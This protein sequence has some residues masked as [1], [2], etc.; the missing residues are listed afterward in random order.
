MTDASGVMNAAVPGALVRSMTGARRFVSYPFSDVCGPVADGPQ[1]S[2]AIA[3]ALSSGKGL[4]GKTWTRSELRIENGA[5]VERYSEYLGY[6]SHILRLA[7][8]IDDI[9][10]S[11]H[12]DCVQRRIKKAFRSGL[13]VFEGS[14][15]SD[16]KEFYRLHLMTRKKLGAP[17]QPFSF[18]RNMHKLLAPGGHL[19][20]L[21][22]KK[23]KK[24]VSGLVLLRYGKRASYKFA[25]SDESFLSLGGNQLA[26]WTAIRKASDDGLLEFD[27]GRSFA[28]NSGLNGFKARWGAEEVRLSYLYSP[29]KSVGIKDEGGSCAKVA[30]ALLR[31]LPP[32]SNRLIGRLFYKYLA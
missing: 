21:I 14:T 24:P 8:P 29:E 1:E 32:F 11:F 30:S 19:S 22:V 7:R 5:S 28:G 16:V 12:K 23:G 20:V 18:F 4:Q 3:A 17:V 2:G 25:A 6:S 13:E 15:I 10:A 26:I 9:Y 31:N 27:F